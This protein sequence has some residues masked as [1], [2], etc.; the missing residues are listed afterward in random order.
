[1]DFLLKELETLLAQK[2]KKEEELREINLKEKQLRDKISEI[3]YGLPPQRKQNSERL[4]GEMIVGKIG[5]IIMVIGFV[6]L[7]KY[8]FD[9][10]LF[11]TEA[12]ITFGYV[13]SILSVYFAYYFR[14]KRKVLSSILFVGATLFAYMLT[15]VC[16]YYFDVFSQLTTLIVLVS[17]SVF[18]CV[19]GFFKNNTLFAF[20]ILAVF[21]SPIFS[22]Y[23]LFDNNFWQWTFFTIFLIVVSCVVALIKQS[24]VLIYAA[25]SLEIIFS[26]MVF[27][28]APDSG[29]KFIVFLLFFLILF[30]SEL[31]IKQ[32]N[33]KVNSIVFQL[34]L[35]FFAIICFN[36]CLDMPYKALSI[37]ILTACFVVAFLVLNLGFKYLY[38][39][40]AT[41]SLS[42]FMLIAYYQR[43]NVLIVWFMVLET[44]FFTVLYSQIKIERYENLLFILFLS[45]VFLSV[46]VFDSYQQNSR[47]FLNLNFFS[48]LLLSLLGFVLK[49]RFHNVSYIKT[50]EISTFVF[51][52]LAVELELYFSVGVESDL[53]F[54][55]LAA[56]FALGIFVYGIKTKKQH[57]RYLGMILAVL[58]AVKIIVYDIWE[59]SLA[60]KA[61]AFIIEGGIFLLISHLCSSFFKKK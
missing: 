49:F 44:L 20:S 46:I 52:I 5:I 56:V 1:M 53:F 55:L 34:L 43:S 33:S 7:I 25:F 60:L 54:S 30:F 32:E 28:D 42:A 15:I 24:S 48:L 27:L 26:L 41:F 18:S 8:L 45:S 12:K 11:S 59:Q 35:T 6:V 14:E 2:R 40:I 16:R 13:L 36:L 47:P 3:K 31:Y 9:R 57:L 4:F 61:V 17:I 51:L 38:F 58:T 22:N 50:A 39:A 37:L 10:G 29:T 23:N 19:V 21:F